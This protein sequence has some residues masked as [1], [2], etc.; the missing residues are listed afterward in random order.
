MGSKALEAYPGAH[1][2]YNIVD[3]PGSVGFSFL[4]IVEQVILGLE[5]VLD[6]I[7]MQLFKECPLQDRDGSPAIAAFG[8]CPFQVKVLFTYM[9]MPHFDP[10]H[11]DPSKS[12][13]EAKAKDQGIFR[14]VVEQAPL[15]DELDLLK[16]G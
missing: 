10:S 12:H 3:S 5:L 16:G 13:D 15:F 4:A 11:F 14:L 1:F 6:D 7:G 2:L 9:D 8:V